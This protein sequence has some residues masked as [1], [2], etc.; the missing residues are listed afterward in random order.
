MARVTTCYG[1]PSHL[2]FGANSILSKLGFH[3]GDPL[4]ALLFSL[5]LQ[6]LVNLI[7]ERL[8]GLSLNAWYLDNGTLVGREG[9]LKEAVDI[10]MEEGPARG[11]ILSTAVTVPA[12]ERPK[13]TI[14]SPAH[15]GLDE[16]PL[17]KGLVPIGDEGVI[18]LGAPLGS[19]E[20]VG[21]EIERKV[22]KVRQVTELLPMLEDPHSESVLLRSC[23]AL[24]KLSFI[25]RAVDA[26]RHAHHLQEFDSI[27][28]EGLTRILG[29]PIGGR[30]WQQGKLPV[31]M[32]GLGLRAAE[33]HGPVAYAASLLSSARITQDL[34][35]P[36][37]DQPGGEEATRLSQ[38]LLRSV[39]TA[40]G[41]ETGAADLV[42][43]SQKQLSL[44]V[45]LEQKRQLLTE[46]GE[47]DV[48]EQAR[49]AC[50]R[51]AEQC[52]PQSPWVA[53]SSS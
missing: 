3:Q 5:V 40:L 37:I 28:R 23:L 34:A 17:E 33:N 48:R 26:S 41:E 8:Q 18:L 13:S 31:S 35:G 20:F 25:L 30:T 12:S 39:S 24:P 16:D 22:E 6:P 15:P 10:L 11:L 53:S 2:L 1:Q 9:D 32:G 50:R 52:S 47:E 45:D 42:G 4:A 38:Q 44:K 14:W 46:V 43:M 51:L 7:Q 27:T 49:L 29:A 36:L 19:E 21:G